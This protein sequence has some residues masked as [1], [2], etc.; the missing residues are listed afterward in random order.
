MFRQHID[1]ILDAEAEARRRLSEARDEA[2][3]LLAQARA[4]REPALE[5]A[6]ENARREAAA[7]VNAGRNDARAERKRLL[8]ETRRRVNETGPKEVSGDVVQR[9]AETIAGLAP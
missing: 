2:R 7:L 1:A 4:A 8:D 9:A 5:A 6:R 3:A